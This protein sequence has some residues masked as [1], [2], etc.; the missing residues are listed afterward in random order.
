MFSV[1][2][3]VDRFVSTELNFFLYWFSDHTPIREKILLYA[4]NS[5][6]SSP[7]VFTSLGKIYLNNFNC[8]GQS[9][10][11][12]N[13]STNALAC[14]KDTFNCFFNLP[15]ISVHVPKHNSSLKDNEF[16]F[17][18][19]G[20]IEGKGE[21][22]FNSL[23]IEFSER[24]ISLAYFIKKRIGFGKVSKIKDKS[25]VRYLCA[26][27]KGLAL[28]LELI[29][30]KFVSQ[31]KY[32]Q[33]LKHNFNQ[34]F[35]CEI[36]PPLKSLSLDNYW[37]AGFTQAV[38]SFHIKLAKSN[39][40]KTGFSVSLEFSIKHCD[41]RTLKLLYEILQRGKISQFSNSLWAYE[42]TGFLTAALLIKY[43]DS[44][45]LFGGQYVDYL[46]FRKV[47]IMITEGKHLEEKGIHKIKSISIKGSSETSTQEV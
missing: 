23:T 10:G 40:L 35:N 14:A 47:Y 3:D 44:F 43:F 31:L 38:G 1:G 26:N 9:A 46:K 21:F 11:N 7:L 18:L 45:Q 5:C 15:K 34:T 19:A 4:G 24:N 29:N 12:F 17:F 27:T 32:E 39:T 28:I 22:G 20:L 8:S 2:L 16:G 25:S 42:S 37:L 6:L 33:L 41:E 36:L 30:G 13:N